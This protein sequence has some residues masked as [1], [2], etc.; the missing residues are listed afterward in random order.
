LLGNTTYWLVLDSPSFNPTRY[1]V[2]GLNTDGNSYSEG[3]AKKSE[4][5]E[6]GNWTPIAGDFAFKTSLG[7]GDTF[8]RK[9]EINGDIHAHTIENSEIEEDAYYQ[10]I[11]EPT[12]IG[13]T[14]YPGSNDPEPKPYPIK[15]SHIAQWKAG[16]SA[17]EING[18]YNV[19]GTETLGNVKINGN[20][21]LGGGAHLTLS[22][23]VW[24][25]GDVVFIQPNAE[26]ALDS[27][28]GENNG[29]IIADG[30]IDVNNNTTINGSGDPLSYL[31][32]LSTNNSID[33]DHP[34]INVAN[35]SE[36]VVFYAKNGMV[37]IYNGSEL[38]GV[39]GYYV[40]LEEQSAITYSPALQ[41]FP[42]PNGGGEEVGTQFGSW[43]EI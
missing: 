38:N 15:D 40:R 36:A 27:S 37:R 8:V 7:V 30:R 32:I 16:V 14:S 26:V 19:V 2:W 1:L 4:N 28:F 34:A 3:V 25:T 17:N 5:Y 6:G 21:T 39:T 13:G 20:L 22:G 29:V 11:I 35:N 24:V 42:I 23:N 10:N 18:D 31:L 41:S 9:M 12:T 33:P 43:H